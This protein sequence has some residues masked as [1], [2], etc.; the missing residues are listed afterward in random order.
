MYSN[1]NLG[2]EYKTPETIEWP[3]NLNYP[4]KR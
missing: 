3:N 1:Q 2:V 4:N